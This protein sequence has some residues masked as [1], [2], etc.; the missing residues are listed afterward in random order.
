[1]IYYFWYFF[2]FFKKLKY[3]L[4][5]TVYESQAYDIVFQNFYML[6]SI[7]SYYKIL[8]ILSVLYNI[9]SFVS[10]LK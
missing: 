1:M 5:K 3:S 4:H 6:Y 7:C 10:L 2:S 9:S 8:A